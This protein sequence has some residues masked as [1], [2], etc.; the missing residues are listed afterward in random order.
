MQFSFHDGSEI[1]DINSA[2]TGNP[3]LR[4]NR[5]RINGYFQGGKRFSFSPFFSVGR[6]TDPNHIDFSG[7]DEATALEWSLHY[8]TPLDSPFALW[9]LELTNQSMQPLIIEEIVLLEPAQAHSQNIFFRE[10]KPN[11]FSFYSNGWQS[12]SSSGAYLPGSRM[13]HSNLGILQ[14]PMV[15]NPGTPSFRS[16]DLFSSDFF[17][18][19]A[20]LETRAGLLLGFLSQ[21]NHFGILTADLR[22]KPI[23]RLWANGDRTVMP[24][25]AHMATDWAICFPLNIDD[26]R[27]ISV[28]FD[29]LAREHEVSALPP[30]LAGWCSWYYYYE[31]IS[32]DILREN[33]NEI[34]NLKNRLPL[35]LV[36]ID[37]GFEAQ[38][39]DWLTTNNRF[40]QGMSPFAEA[41]RKKGFTPGLW[42]APFILHPNSSTTQEHPDW[43][44]RKAN[45][46]LARA[47]FE[48]NSLAVGLDLTVPGALEY[49]CE[50]VDTAV[51]GWGYPYLKLDFLYAAA[52]EC[53][54]HDPTRTRAQVLRAGMEALRRAAGKETFLLGCG[55]PL[56]SVIGLVQ[57][58]R[59]GADVSGSW[60]P[61][62]FGIGFPI[63]NEPHMPC[64]RN[65]IQNIL[66]RAEM[67]RRLWVNAPDCLLVRPDSR[68][69]LDE[70]RSLA[71]A[72]GMT[73]GS[74]LVSDDM[75]ALPEDR[76][77]IAAALLPPM[78]VDAHVLDWMDAEMPRK[79]RIDLTGSTGDWN[80]LSYFNWQD[81]VENTVLQ[82]SD[83]RLD[84]SKYWVRSFWDERVWLVEEGMNLYRGKLNPH[85]CLLMAVRPFNP[86]RPAYLGSSSH[87]SQGLEVEQWKE[88]GHA[89]TFTLSTGRLAKAIMDLFIPGRIIRAVFS[90]REIPADEIGDRLF[91]FNLTVDHTGQFEVVYSK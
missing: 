56:G 52:L 45:G 63:R 8:A 65:S 23:L 43:L 28:Y 78:Q 41:I 30:V 69:N 22:G 51:N 29:A 25:A 10:E 31:Q 35:D 48:W 57:A 76:I 47:G 60:K 80:L 6:N 3:V 67:H 2:N 66:T 85:A 91:R 58:M 27:G 37:D 21:R 33:L 68:L 1:F 72:I 24:P 83:Y 32:A 9:M 59:I 71:T 40:P 18:V 86:E 17:G 81:S 42:L 12:W 79:L 11:R 39:E 87:I 82:L 7:R 75:T 36:Q 50:V 46:K 73:G 16:K 26:P 62:Q 49:V 15:I 64:A 70:V 61:R 38:V 53:Q 14:N 20:D 55:V 4:G 74:V 77:A 13:R 19:L 54:Y 89:I 90:G 44:L 34:G 84:S 88:N 5:V